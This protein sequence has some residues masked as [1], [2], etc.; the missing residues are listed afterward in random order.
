MTCDIQQSANVNYEAYAF[1]FFY[2]SLFHLFYLLPEKD[3]CIS[4]NHHAGLVSLN[5]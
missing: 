4:K 5:E 2:N 1:F 3:P